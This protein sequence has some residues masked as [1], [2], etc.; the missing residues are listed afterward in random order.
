MSAAD[1]PSHIHSGQSDSSKRKQQ[2]RIW[3]AVGDDSSAHFWRLLSSVI[4][5]S[6]AAKRSRHSL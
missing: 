2:R 4:A 3:R 5:R 6:A 1:G